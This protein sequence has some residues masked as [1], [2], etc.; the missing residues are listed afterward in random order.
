MCAN[1]AGGWRA[2]SRA[3]DLFT[4]DQ[5]IC[6]WAP[7]LEIRNQAEGHHSKFGGLSRGYGSVA[8][9]TIHEIHVYAKGKVSLNM[10]NILS[11]IVHACYF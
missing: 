10:P 2:E 9:R 1:C 5:K 3:D 7:L 6:T 11:S 4:A 8:V